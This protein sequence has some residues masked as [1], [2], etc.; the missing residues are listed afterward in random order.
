LRHKESAF[1][2][3]Y[4]RRTLRIFPPYYLALGLILVSALVHGERVD[5]REIARQGLFLSSATPALIRVAVSRLFFHMPAALP[6]YVGVTQYSMLQFK[7]CFGIYWSLSVEE[8][9]YLLWAPV[10][11]K[12]SRRIVLLTSVAPL[13]LCPL[14]RGLVHATPHI[15]ESI[16]F[17][18]R[19]DSLAAGGCVALLFWGMDHGRLKEKA[20]DR[21]LISIIILSSCGLFFLIKVCGISPGVDVRTTLAFS[22]FGYSMLA[23]LCASL[24]G[25]LVRWSGELGLVSTLLRSKS[26]IYVGTISYTIYLIHLPTY[27]V[28][29]LAMGKLLG[30]DAVESNRWAAVLCGLLATAGAILFAGLSWKYIEAPM[31]RLKDSV[32]PIRSAARAVLVKSEVERSGPICA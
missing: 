26:A 9:F 15:G 7:D 2:T 19:F 13:L 18:F 31:I 4:W 32:F 10:I 8:L 23:L 30:P 3:F 20:L 14:L 24:V 27:V 28:V 29:Q 6:A 12:G 22:V 11:L 1:R 17:V 5:Y 21:G 25:A 16:G